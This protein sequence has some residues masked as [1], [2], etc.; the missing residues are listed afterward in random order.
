MFYKRNFDFLIY[1]VKKYYNKNLVIFLKFEY[2]INILI[3][4]IKYLIGI[5]I[6]YNRWL[7]I[8]C[9]KVLSIRKF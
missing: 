3:I 7:K 5:M 1:M 4:I 8:N 2:L 6:K 9:N